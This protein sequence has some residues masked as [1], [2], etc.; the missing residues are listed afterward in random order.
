MGRSSKPIGIFL[1]H[2]HLDHICGLPFFAPVYAKEGRIHVFGPKARGLSPEKILGALFNDVLFPM[3]L[4][5]LPAKIEFTGLSEETTSFSGFKVESV[6][7]NHPGMTLG[8]ILT[9]GKRRVAY[10]TD[11]EPA[12]EH[13]HLSV[14]AG[15]YEAALI[16]KMR[17][18]DLLVQDAHCQDAD[19]P[20]YRGWGHSPV[21]YGLELAEKAQVKRVSL[22]HFSPHETDAVLKKALKGRALPRGIK[23]ALAREGESVEL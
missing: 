11:H 6:R 20:K 21:A 19:Y 9:K 4:P 22:I 17:G 15:A 1:S 16:E 14:N 2:Y 3:K 7:I 10:L 13:N 23:V 12:R 18:V 8:Y 5:A